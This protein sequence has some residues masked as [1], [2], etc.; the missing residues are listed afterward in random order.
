[1]VVNVKIYPGLGTDLGP[2]FVVTTDIGSVSYNYTLAELLAGIQITVEDNATFIIITSLG[3]CTN[4]L[5]LTIG[6]GG[7][8]TTTTTIADI[9]TSTTTSSTTTTTTTLVP[10]SSYVRMD[11]IDADGTI[12][13]NVADDSLQSIFSFTPY[14]SS[15]NYYYIAFRLYNISG[16]TVY[17][18]TPIIMN[19]T[20]GGKFN[21][22]TVTGTA[23]LTYGQSYDTTIEIDATILSNGIYTC[24]F[25]QE[26]IV[27]G[28]PSVF[29]DVNLR[30]QM[31]V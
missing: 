29:F 20:T 19:D 21:I 15:G 10:L 2:N 26:L 5:Y 8:T 11:Y 13:S 4:N 16:T 28:Y 25:R 9:T 23:F 6:A 18:Q 7:T 12:F 17:P 14:G 1:M 31:G 30:L 27:S 24:T 3:I 22:N